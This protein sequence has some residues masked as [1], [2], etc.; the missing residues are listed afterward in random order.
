MAISR[1][2]PP[3]GEAAT[4]GVPLQRPPSE[5]LHAAELER[6]RAQ[7]TDPRPPG[8]SLGLRAARAFILGDAALGIAPKIVAPVASIER[9]LVTLATGRGLMLVGEPGTA[10]SLLSELL[11]AAVSGVSTLTIQGGASTTEDQI[12]YGWNYALLINEGPSPRALVPA[13]LYQGMQ[14]GRIVRFEEITRAPLEVQDCLLGMLS[15]R[16]M[17]VPELAGEHAMLYAR[18]GFNIIATANTRDR[19]VN[20]MSA[21]LKR[22]FDF[23][24]VFPILDFDRELSLVQDASARLLAQSG[25]PHAVPAPV[26]ELLVSTFRD[27]RGAPADGQRGAPPDAAM[28]RL[29]A[30]MSTAEAV[31]VA[32]AVGVRAWFLERREG[33][34][35]DLVDCIAGTIVKDNAD[36]RAKLRRYFEQKAAK[37]TG[38]HWRA[39][40]EARH[41]LP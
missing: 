32:H 23:E 7:D 14:Q 24:T 40:Y 30:V 37:R 38:G 31:N 21:A 34:P 5:I 16:V 9:M 25:I 28:D 29:S 17:A 18:E 19:G 8:W 11:A 39:Y 10:K 2:T 35:A 20:E 41:R 33:S 4:A 36:D 3:P 27:L 22:R 26:L 12:K 1:K 6:L 13:P 15:D